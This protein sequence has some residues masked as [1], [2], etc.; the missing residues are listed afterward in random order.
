MVLTKKQIQKIKEIIEQHFNAFIFRNLGS[1]QLTDEERKKLPSDI[2]TS[3]HFKNAYLAGKHRGNAGP[4]ELSDKS[5]DQFLAEIFNRSLGSSNLDQKTLELVKSSITHYVQNLKH[6]T[7]D[8]IVRTVQDKNKEAHF[9]TI[10]ESPNTYQSAMRESRSIGELVS[11]LK[12]KTQDMARDWDRTVRTELASIHNQGAVSAI[13]E[14]NNDVKKDDILVYCQGPL[15][16]ATC[17]HCREHYHDGSSYKIYR[18]SELLANGTNIGVNSKSWQA[19][20]PPMHP[21]CRHRLIE[22]LPGWSLDEDGRQIYVG[23]DHH[24]K[25]RDMKKADIGYKLDLLKGKAFPIGTIRV[26]G[27]QKFIKHVDGWVGLSEGKKK[28]KLI[29]FAI[30]GKVHA[31]HSDEVHGNFAKENQHRLNED[32]TPSSK[33]KKEPK[34]KTTKDIHTKI[35]NTLKQNKAVIAE[36]SGEGDKPVSKDHWTKVLNDSN[37]VGAVVRNPTTGKKFKIIG[38]ENHSEFGQT[39]EVKDLETGD[40]RVLDPK[41]NYEVLS[42]GT[43]GAS[44]SKKES[45]STLLADPE[46]RRSKIRDLT[47]GKTKSP[48]LD[49][50]EKINPPLAKALKK[51]TGSGYALMRQVQYKGKDIAGTAHAEHVKN[52]EEHFGDLPTHEGRINRFIQ[53]DDNTFDKLFKEGSTYTTEAFSSFTEQ[54]ELAN[55][56]KNTRIIVTEN[57]SGRKLG[58]LSDHPHEKEVLVPKGVKYKVDHIKKMGSSRLVWLTEVME[59]SLSKEND[60]FN[61]LFDEPLS[62][63]DSVEK[64]ATF[65]GHKLHKR[66]KFQGMDISIENRKGSKRHWKD[67]DGNEGDTLMQADYGYIRRT[68]GNDGDHV[69]AYIGP[70]EES[71][72]VF[73]IHQVRPDSGEFDEDKVMLG[74]DS[75]D[76]AKEMYL[77]HYNS[78]KFFGSMDELDMNTFQDKVIGKEVDIIKAKLE[79]LTR[80]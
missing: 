71:T 78:P 14:R 40:H 75:A 66:I 48:N 73:V 34:A 39:F 58:N 31:N 7:I 5:L 61:R 32:P 26:Y 51:W 74:F 43:P 25:N 18:L 70:N 41:R 55:F 52:L 15:D 64:S 57:K 60:E 11:E 20:V 56:N 69:D 63:R 47:E 46:V 37:H 68:V 27:G 1:D 16:D 3:D 12:D 13:V 44:K 45:A 30:G 42:F 17:D 28:G 4:E 53:L 72:K 54:D 29:D 62:D 8:T 50:L 59:K 65:S 35:E 77:K 19:V 76:E 21:R 38:R 24:E 79:W 9:D 2:S 49:K 36:L 33:E 6:R 67:R 80:K 23:P 22:L 10:G